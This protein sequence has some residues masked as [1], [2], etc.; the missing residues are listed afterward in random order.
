MVTGVPKKVVDLDERLGFDIF[1]GSGTELRLVNIYTNTYKSFAIRM[2]H[3]KL[4]YCYCFFKR[5][6]CFYYV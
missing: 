1:P 4:H 6:Q 2:K 3:E 5:Y